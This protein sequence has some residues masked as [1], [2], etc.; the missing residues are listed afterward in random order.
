VPRFTSA[1]EP[2]R[3]RTRQTFRL[4]RVEET[5]LDLT[6]VAASGERACAWIVHGIGQ[7][8]TTQVRLRKA[9]DSRP[10]IRFRA[11]IEEA[12][13][14]DMQGVH[15]ALEYR[16]VRWVENPHGLPR[17]RHQALVRRDGRREYRDVLY[18][19]YDLA[20]E[21]DGRIAHPGDTRWNDI[22]RD[23]AAAADGLKTLRY[24][25]DD[26]SRRR[27]LVADEVYRALCRSGLPVTG[28]PCSPTCPVTRAR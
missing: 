8:L 9:L 7:G 14:P 10:H 1:D 28:R 21:L 25:S 6:Q 5:V 19:G 22:R 11:E 18:D 24:G 27:C 16:Y 15:S 12:L 23:N 20:V 3:R 2:L 4:G 26:L 13:S 17:G